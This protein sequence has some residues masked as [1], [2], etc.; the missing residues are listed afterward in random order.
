M[1]NISN[2]TSNFTAIHV[3]PRIKDQFNIERACVFLLTVIFPVGVTRRFAIDHD[4]FERKVMLFPVAVPARDCQPAIIM[5][6]AAVAPVDEEVTLTQSCDGEHIVWLG[7]D[8]NPGAVS[9]FW[10][11]EPV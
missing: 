5:G 3:Y 10:V 7:F 4:I 6:A 11:R 2:I 9:K 1:L 8:V